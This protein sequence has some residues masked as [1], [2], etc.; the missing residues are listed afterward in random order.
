MTP[1]NF[2]RLLLAFTLALPQQAQQKKEETVTFT[3][4]STLVIVNCF[5]RDKSGNPVEGLKKE[6][7]KLLE[8]G[9]PQN[10]SV[11][12]FQKL[13]DP[14]PAPASKPKLIASVTKAAPKSATPKPPAAI[15]PSKSGELRYPRPPSDR[16]PVRHVIHAPAGSNPRPE[17]RPE[18][19]ARPDDPVRRGRYSDVHQRPESPAGFHR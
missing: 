5:V 16:V 11:F 3:S 10:I 12:E 4:T 18:I 1:S 15:T 9:K 17:G 14:A 7:F 6:D 2:L 8:D 13:E 19:S